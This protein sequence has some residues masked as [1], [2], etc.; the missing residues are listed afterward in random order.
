MKDKFLER[1]Q[2]DFEYFKQTILKN[3]TKE[4]IFDKA[5][6]YAVLDNFASGIECFLEEETIDEQ[7]MMKALDCPKN[8][9]TLFW[10][11]FT[12]NDYDLNDFFKEWAN[13]LPNIIERFLERI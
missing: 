1:I 11:D 7:L 9:I 4:E 2:K 3:L 6:K 5:Y 12:Q 13:E 8:L 10:E